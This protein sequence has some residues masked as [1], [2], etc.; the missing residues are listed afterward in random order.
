MTKKLLVLS[1]LKMKIAG[2]NL[3]VNVKDNALILTKLTKDL[4][5]KTKFKTMVLNSIQE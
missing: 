1:D 5:M 2:M 3:L 4:K